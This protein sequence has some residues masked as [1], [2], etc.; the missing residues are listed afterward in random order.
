MPESTLTPADPP[1]LA[2]A[3]DARDATQP[4]ATL[5]GAD[6]PAA[7]LDAALITLETA[8]AHYDARLNVCPPHEDGSKRPGLSTWKQ[9]QDQRVPR[10]TVENQYRSGRQGIGWLTGGGSGSLEVLEFDDRQTYETFKTAA[11]NI[12]LA[13]LVER[14]EAGYVSDTP[15]GGVHWPYRCTEIAGNTKLARRPKLPAEMKAPNDRVKVLIE[16]RGI[17][18]YIVEAPSGGSVHPTG[19]PYVLR[20]GSVQTIA[21]ITP[22][23]REDIHALAR[24]FDAMPKQEAAP[25]R[26]TRAARGGARPGDDFNARATWE[27][28]LKGW[29]VHHREG[30]VTFWTRPG[31]DPRLGSSGTTNYKGSG[32]LYVFSSATPFDPER[33][34]SKFAAHA[35]LEHGGDYAAAAKALA[36]Q[37]YGHAHR[38]GHRPTASLERSLLEFPLTDS[39]NG[40]L[41]A[42]LYGDGLRFDHRRGKWLDWA[43]HWWQRDDDGL[44]DRRAKDLARER[45]KLAAEIED[46]AARKAWARWGITSESRRGREATLALAEAEP[47]LADAG[48]PLG[49]RPVAA[50]R[51]ERRRRPQDRPTSPRPTGGPS[52]APLVSCVRR[53]RR[54]SAVAVVHL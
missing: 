12:G 49:R 21:T 23:E 11:A 28:V 37:G 17:G 9:F 33:S 34:Y 15:G 4:P 14:I 52:D 7:A 20:R 29:Q 46:E 48:G 36:A 1:R 53:C 51:G 6:S 44:A 8:M 13:E 35:V 3:L 39:G 47:P 38:N 10:S 54:V 50:G 22:Q 42:V 31:K 40:E 45:L 25:A 16:T 26:E 32:L 5:A 30:E 2:A 27:D 41:F 19:R 24:S 43:G 18:G